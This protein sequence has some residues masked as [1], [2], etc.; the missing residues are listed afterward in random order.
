MLRPAPKASSQVEISVYEQ[1][2]AATV[3]PAPLRIPPKPKTDETAEKRAVFGISKSTL[4]EE[5]DRNEPGVEVKAG[6][7][8]AVAPDDRKLEPGDE[9]SLPI[10]TEEFLV[11]RMPVMLAEVRI[12]YPQ[13]ARENGIEGPVVMDLLIDDR[14]G[15]REAK[16]IEG[17]APVL[18]D[19]ALE[20]VKRIQ[21]KPALVVDK[22]VAV[23][24][25]Y[26]YR[27]VLE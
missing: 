25:R 26:I 20:A 7:T 11:T 18:N 3:Q 21:F 15:V 17:P 19:A 1:P 5:P 22:P 13:E 23:R 2:R 4:T 12:P 27:F 8:L 10:P 24:I 9:A 14:G 6:N 16:L